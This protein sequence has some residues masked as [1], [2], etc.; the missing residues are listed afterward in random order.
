MVVVGVGVEVEVEVE[1]AM[2][3]NLVGCMDID[4]M[5]HNQDTVAVVEV[6]VEDNNHLLLPRISKLY[7][8][9]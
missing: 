5:D 9:D 4:Y 3:C 8:K 7:E 1:V 2:D 6:V